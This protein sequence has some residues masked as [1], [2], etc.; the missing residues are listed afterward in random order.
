MAAA[1]WSGP[2]RLG[3]YTTEA[4]SVARL[5]SASS[6]P[7]SLE[8]TFSTR[9][10]QDAQ[11]MPPMSSVHDSVSAVPAAV[12]TGAVAVGSA[13]GVVVTVCS[14]WPRWVA[15]RRAVEVWCS[16]WSPGRRVAPAKLPGSGLARVVSGGGGRRGA[17]AWR[18][19]R[20]GRGGWAVRRGGGRAAHGWRSCRSLQ[21]LDSAGSW[22]GLSC[23]VATVG[24][25]RLR[26]QRVAGLVDGG[27]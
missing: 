18:G 16:G 25:G 22:G 10:T 1:I 3:S 17:R 12:S 24:V 19:R 6:T 23:G 15:A 27:G 9:R 14:L 11:V 4:A 13:V 8:R 26:K 2:T 5:T 7:S 21:V 20:G